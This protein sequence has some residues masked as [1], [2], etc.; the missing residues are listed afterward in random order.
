[1][2]KIEKIDPSLYSLRTAEQLEAKSRHTY[3]AE[4]VAFEGERRNRKDPRHRPT[5]QEDD[6]T[7]HHDSFVGAHPTETLGIL[8]IVA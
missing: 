4:A 3:S 1:M 5:P 7:Q 2:M 6:T 8:D